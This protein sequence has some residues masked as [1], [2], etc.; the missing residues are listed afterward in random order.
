M[1]MIYLAFLVAQMW[2]PLS[3]IFKAGWRECEVDDSDLGCALDGYFV[4]LSEDFRLTA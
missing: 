1:A 2:F 3:A 4:G